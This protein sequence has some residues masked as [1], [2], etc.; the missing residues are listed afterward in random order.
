MMKLTVNQQD[1]DA[2]ARAFDQNAKRGAARVV[3][4]IADVAKR[5]LFREY[6][7][8]GWRDLARLWDNTSI[9]V[10]G[11]AVETEVYNRI[12][13]QKVWGRTT[14]TDLGRVRTTKYWIDGSRLVSILEYGAK[15]H[16]IAAN[17]SPASFLA[18]PSANSNLDSRTFKYVKKNG[19]GS[20]LTPS[21]GDIRFV[22]SV[23]HPGV[24]GAFLLKRAEMASV[25]ALDGAVEGS[26]RV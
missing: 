8:Q 21:K 24:S 1:I 10:V 7:D 4:E 22:R 23:L 12:E 3:K 5:Y 14:R 17:D 15:P 9:R 11:T 26:F 6:H 16:R 13:G 25:A 19:P 2:F 18:F 20:F